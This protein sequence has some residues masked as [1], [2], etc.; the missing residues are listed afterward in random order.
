MLKL[1]RRT[2]QD[3]LTDLVTWANIG[4]DTTTNSRIRPAL[5][6]VINNDDRQNA[7]QWCDVGFATT[8][9]LEQLSGNPWFDD[10]KAI[11]RRRNKTIETSAD[12]LNCY[13]DGLRVICIPSPRVAATRVILKQYE[14]LYT[15]ATFGKD[16]VQLQRKALG[17][18]ATVENLTLYM[19][20][21]LEQLAK[22][23][24]APIDFHDLIEGVHR[25]P[26]DFVDHLTDILSKYTS[27]LETPERDSVQA[28][29]EYLGWCLASKVMDA[30]Q[31][32]RH[33]ISTPETL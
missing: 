22:N 9:I 32:A 27:S 21:A 30:P 18:K 13:Y 8:T 25:L 33:S 15:E 12:L 4:F 1:R 7:L 11:W 2:T 26:Q 6:L 3:H 29:R 23:F 14:K 10:Q 20:I 28:F 19:E 24:E 17:M 31:G 16:R 5:I